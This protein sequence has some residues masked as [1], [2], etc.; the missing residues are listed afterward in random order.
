MVIQHDSTYILYYSVS[1]VGSQNSTIGYATSTTME[2]GSWVDQGSVGVWSNT[3][4]DYNAIDPTMVLVDS[5]YYLSFGSY[6]EDLMLVAYGS[7]A[8]T[9]A[10]TPS[11]TIYQPSGNHQ[12]EASFPYQHGGYFYMFWSEGQ[13][14]EY[15]ESKPSAG[16]EYKVRVCRSTAIGGPFTDN[17]GTSCLDGGGED[18]LES[19]GQVYGPG[20]Q[21]ILDD[22]THGPIMYY[23]YGMFLLPL[24]LVVFLNQSPSLS[25]LTIHPLK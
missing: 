25:L 2:N 12:V 3:G 1:T 15:V 16:G 17:N 14:N 10:G 24:K 13:A 9:V 19:H 22:S 11:Q 20:G 7:D 23:R 21:G 4:S 6:W 18:V 5:T 8:I